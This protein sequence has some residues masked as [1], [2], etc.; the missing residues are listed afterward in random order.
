MSLLLTVVPPPNADVPAAAVQHSYLVRDGQSLIIGRG[1]KLSD[2]VISSDRALSRQHFQVTCG[3]SGCTLKDL[4]SSHGT[5]V[6]GQ[7]V[8]ETTLSDGDQVAAGETR[9][10]VHIAASAAPDAKRTEP[11][12]E[13]GATSGEAASPRRR[14]TLQI[15]QQQ[16]TG[17]QPA[18]FHWLFA[19]I[20][21]GETVTLGRVPER[22][23]IGFADDPQMSGRHLEFVFDKRRCRATDLN[24][25]NGSFLNGQR[26]S[27]EL[28][29]HGDEIHIGNT[30]ILVHVYF[31]EEAETLEPKETVGHVEVSRGE[32]RQQRLKSRGYQIVNTTPFPVVPLTGRIGFPGHSLTLIVK[33]T[34]QLCPD[35]VMQLADEQVPPTGDVPFPDTDDP[36]AAP[37]Y[38][39]DF[40]FFKP[41]ADVLLTG[42]CHAPNG[43]P[44]QR[45]RVSLQAGQVSRALD[46]CGPRSWHYTRREWTVTEPELFS[47][48]ELRYG[49]CFGGQG[50]DANPEGIG[51]YD[52]QQKRSGDPL[53]LPQILPAG[54]DLQSPDDTVEVAG[55]APEGKWHGRRRQQLGTYDDHWEKHGWPWFPS[56][57]SWQHYNAAPASLQ[58]E[59]Y[60]RGDEQIVLQNLHPVHSELTSQ[61]P[62]LRI[63][64]FVNPAG[65]AF[66]EVPTHLDTLWIDSDN[67]QAILVWRG[68]TE[69]LNEECEDIRHVFVLS[70]PLDEPLLS[71]NDCHAL[72]LN[73]LARREAQFQPAPETPP[74]PAGETVSADDKAPN[75]A[76]AD[77]A[78]AEAA[79]SDTAATAQARQLEDQLKQVQTQIREA[80]IAAGVDP[81][82][83]DR[84]VEA[85]T[86]RLAKE[87]G[88]DGDTVPADFHQKVSMEFWKL[89]KQ[90]HDAQVA[91]GVEPIPLPDPP[92]ESATAPDKTAK[93]E[94]AGWTREKVVSHHAA[95]GGFAGQLLAGLDLSELDLSG[96]DFKAAILQKT[97]LV[98]AN[99]SGASFGLANLSESDLTSANLTQATLEQ[100]DLSKA[101]LHEACLNKS[102]LNGAIMAGT[103]LTSATV[104]Q[105]EAI[106][107]NFAQADLTNADFSSARLDSADFTEARLTGANLTQCSLVAVRL[108]GASARDAR[109]DYAD[110]TKARA[111]E[112]D[113][114]MACFHQ[115]YAPDSIWEQANLIGADFSWARLSGANLTRAI[116]KDGRLSAADLSGA[117]LSKAV[118]RRAFLTDANLFEANVQQADFRHADLSRA[119]LYGAEVSDAMWDNAVL[120]SVNWKMTKL[121][122]EQST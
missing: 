43:Q 20:L 14:V 48:V 101:V 22:S 74:A 99:L 86:V 121:A 37:R 33:A 109:F 31:E 60:L 10:V 61:L 21:P 85:E 11:S 83:F 17:G 79:A 53:P 119:S 68:N 29:R 104:R 95:G 65:A 54:A 98:G 113:C 81:A 72:L 69:I 120:D 34:F 108:G 51:F 4:D 42:H 78:A 58:V 39:N 49:L 44:V 55:F 70:Q 122:Q 66:K 114:V 38:E 110:L 93:P 13:R 111:S 92:S 40:A 82:A 91:A 118:L 32:R 76:T 18:Q 63:R 25:S 57:F 94:P 67:E 56:D 52:D 73:E 47:S 46:I 88:L 84:Q 89:Q 117:R 6:N 1:E 103:W 64:C 24:S 106:R 30:Y 90:V 59:E 107:T 19:T 62:G 115:V 35:G 27:N 71:V 97:S 112:C 77:T 15:L 87:W 75:T 50:W 12:T 16:S 116:L 45:L 2:V 41:K 102:N 80:Q 100:A 26:F 8:T 7:A 23:D 5:Q 105:A 96:A 36:A 3:D 28:V 9:F